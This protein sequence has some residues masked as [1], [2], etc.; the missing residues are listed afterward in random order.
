MIDQTTIAEAEPSFLSMENIV[1][2]DEKWFDMTKRSRKYYLLPEEQDHVQTIHNKNSIGKVMFLTAVAKPRYNE[3][4]KSCLMEKSES[5][6]LLKK[7][8]PRT[9]K[10]G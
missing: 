1:H 9:P 3:Q 4:K 2:I 7:P 5:G 6:H 10:I 8:Q